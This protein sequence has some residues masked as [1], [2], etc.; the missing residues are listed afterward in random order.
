LECPDRVSSVGV[1]WVV[2]FI[3]RLKARVFSLSYIRAPPVPGIPFVF[4]ATGR[5]AGDGESPGYSSGAFSLVVV[6]FLA[7]MVDGLVT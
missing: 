3:P 1:E 4:Y 2:G 5:E 6:A 7:I